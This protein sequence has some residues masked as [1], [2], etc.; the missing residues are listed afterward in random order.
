MA[1][2]A[3]FAELRGHVFRRGL[4]LDGL[5]DRQDLAVLADVERPA[6]GEA[7]LAFNTPYAVATLLSGR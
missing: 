1:G 5:V 2:D 4:G 3:E 7:A 6:I